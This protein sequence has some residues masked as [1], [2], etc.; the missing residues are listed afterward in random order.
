MK[1]YKLIINK[2]EIE[3]SAKLLNVSRKRVIRY[4]NLSLKK[5]N[6]S[7]AL[8]MFWSDVIMFNIMTTKMLKNS[9]P[10]ILEEILNPLYTEDDYEDV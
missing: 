2:E 5:M 4:L 6:D 8:R 9:S 10:Q 7:K 1:N 3:V